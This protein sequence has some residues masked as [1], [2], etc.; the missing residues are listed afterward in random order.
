MCRLAHLQSSYSGDPCSTS[1]AGASPDQE[2]NALTADAAT[3]D[4]E[5]AQALLEMPGYSKI[6]PSDLDQIRDRALVAQH[7]EEAN[8]ICD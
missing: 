8:W 6:L 5:L 2:R 1:E 3:L 4:P 7:G